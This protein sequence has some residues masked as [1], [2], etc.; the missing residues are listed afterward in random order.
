MR[1]Y[2]DSVSQ[3]KQKWV[4]FYIVAPDQD[5][6]EQLEAG[7]EYLHDNRLI[8]TDFMAV[9]AIVHSY[10]NQY[11]EAGCKSCIIVDPKLYKKLT[12]I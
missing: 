1:V 9:N 10:L 4:M 12:S 3:E 7:F 6:K 5:A 2:D 8:D 11:R